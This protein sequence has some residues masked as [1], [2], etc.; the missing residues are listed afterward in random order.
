M[1]LKLVKMLNKNTISMLKIFAINYTTWASI[2]EKKGV[3]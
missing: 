2:Q 1:C 3:Q